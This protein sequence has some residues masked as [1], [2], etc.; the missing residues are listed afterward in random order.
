MLEFLRSF[1]IGPFAIFDFTV[2]YL[3]FYILSPI[4]IKIFNF[5]GITITRAN[6]M[7]LVLPISIL[8]HILVG[9]Y[10]PLTKMFLETGNYFILKLVILYMLY[11][12]LEGIIF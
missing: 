5:L 11:K 9:T 7:W 3:G 2:S 6:I 12:G 4:I 1:R 10:T 8:T